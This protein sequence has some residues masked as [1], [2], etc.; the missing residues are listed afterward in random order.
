MEEKYWHERWKKSEL[1][2]HKSEFNPLLLQYFPRSSLPQAAKVLVPLCGKSLD[3]IWLHQQGYSV[4]G[5]ELSEIAIEAFFEEQEISFTKNESQS[6]S[7]WTADSLNIVKQDFFQ[8]SPVQAFD[9]IYDR[10]SLVAL[11]KKM[12]EDYAS[13]IATLLIPGGR[14]LLLAFSYNDTSLDGPPFSVTDAEVRQLFH[15][16][17]DIEC[18]LSRKVSLGVPRF[19]S[20]GVSECLENVYLMTKR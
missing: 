13:K 1:N 6:F 12:R 11:P 9:A 5:V 2:F 10:A 8:F 4:T 15:S 3:L 18:M 7:E 20:A 16:H 17:F 19:E 14:Y